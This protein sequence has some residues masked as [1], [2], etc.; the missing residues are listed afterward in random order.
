MERKNAAN[1]GSGCTCPGF[2]GLC[3][4]PRI[5]SICRCK[6]AKI[7]IIAM[8]AIIAKIANIAKIVIAKMAKMAKMAEIAKMVKIAVIAEIATITNIAKEVCQDKDNI[9]LHTL[10]YLYHTYL[11]IVNIIFYVS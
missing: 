7:A 4:T 10:F 11:I 2:L 3:C 1:R 5:V 8:I 6:I 9:Y